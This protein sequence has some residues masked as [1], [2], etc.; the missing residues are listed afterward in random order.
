MKLTFCSPGDLAWIAKFRIFILKSA[1]LSPIP[2]F[3]PNSAFYP[4]FRVF[5][6]NSAFLSPIPLLSP[7]PRFIL[8]SGSA[9]RFRIPGTAFYPYPAGRSIIEGANIHIFVFTDCK[10]EITFMVGECV[11]FFIHEFWRIVKTNEWAQRTS[12]FSDPS[13]TSE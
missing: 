5:I 8:D 4:Q 2:R 12:E 3:I 9:F 11:R 7:I 13:Q 6:L 10:I 1:F